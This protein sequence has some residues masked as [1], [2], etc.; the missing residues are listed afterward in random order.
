MKI[1]K[2][3]YKNWEKIGNRENFERNLWKFLIKVKNRENNWEKSRKLV[4]TEKISKILENYKK[5]I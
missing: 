5:K 2:K 4:K 1:A 3:K